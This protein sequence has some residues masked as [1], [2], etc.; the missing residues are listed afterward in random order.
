MNETNERICII[1][2]CRMKLSFILIYLQ[3]FWYYRFNC[4]CSE[5]CEDL[6]DELNS[7]VDIMSQWFYIVRLTFD[8]LQQW[9]LLIFSLGRFLFFA[10]RWHFGHN[11][12]LRKVYHQKKYTKSF[13]N[14][15]VAVY[16]QKYLIVSF[17]NVK[18]SDVSCSKEATAQCSKCQSHVE[19]FTQ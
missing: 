5:R 6:F 3:E 8:D 4:F 14:C 2:N 7:I 11:L 12:K 19:A 15:Y 9:F 17:R 16:K 1:F 18:S 13:S 10:L